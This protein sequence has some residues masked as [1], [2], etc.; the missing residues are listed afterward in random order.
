MFRI[1]AQILFAQAEHSQP[2]LR[3]EMNPDELPPLTVHETVKLAF[4]FCFLWFI[5]NWSINASLD[6]TSVASTTI[7][8]SLSGMSS[9]S[10]IKVPRPNICVGFF[11]LIIGR[12]FRVETLTIGKIGAVV[13]RFVHSKAFHI[14]QVDPRWCEVLQVVYWLPAPILIQG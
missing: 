1:S 13:T 7:L 9:N 11:T 5:A 3:K 12:L 6:Y 8:S 14:P 4:V 2:R 10:W